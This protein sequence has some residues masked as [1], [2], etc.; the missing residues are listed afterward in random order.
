VLN[1]IQTKCACVIQFLSQLVQYVLIETLYETVTTTTVQRACI[2]HPHQKTTEVV[3][4]VSSVFV[5]C[6]QIIYNSLRTSVARKF[7]YFGM[8]VLLWCQQNWSA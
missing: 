4:V 8:G 5:N 1:S 3:F 2:A 6:H 7:K